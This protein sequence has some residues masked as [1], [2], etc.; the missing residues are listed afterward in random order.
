MQVTLRW[1]PLRLGRIPTVPGSKSGACFTTI[2][3]TACAKPG[4]LR[5]ITLIGKSQG[6]ASRELSA[7]TGIANFASG[8]QRLA[9]AR[10][11]DLLLEVLVE[12]I[13]A[14]EDRAGP[15]VADRRTIE[16]HDGEHFLRR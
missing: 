7:T 10:A 2:S 4:C 16:A 3:V 14:A 15:P 5:P 11:H 6:N 9:P 13:H 1:R 8:R 12:P